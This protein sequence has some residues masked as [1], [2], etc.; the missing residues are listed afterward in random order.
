MASCSSSSEGIFPSIGTVLGGPMVWACRASH[1]FR[2][3][4]LDEEDEEELIGLPFWREVRSVVDLDVD[5]YLA[6]LGLRAE[7]MRRGLLE[8]LEIVSAAHRRLRKRERS[9]GADPRKAYADMFSGQAVSPAEIN[10]MMGWLCQRL[11]LFFEIRFVLA[12]R[13]RRSGGEEGDASISPATT[14]RAA[15][16]QGWGPAT[17]ILLFVSVSSS[18]SKYLVD[19]TLKSTLDLLSVEEDDDAPSWEGGRRRQRLVKHDKLFTV[20]VFPEEEKKEEITLSGNSAVSSWRRE[21]LFDNR[22]KRP[23]AHFVQQPLFRYDER[24]CVDLDDDD[25]DDDQAS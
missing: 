4:V 19:C 12:R 24:A 22:I 14:V 6:F 1:Y 23:H 11:Q 17:H 13:R 20:E 2:P 7:E 9:H 3:A 18:S 15:Q 16:G 25:D 21:L 10:M 5:A 8:T